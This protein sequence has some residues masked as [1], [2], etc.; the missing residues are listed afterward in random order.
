ILDNETYLKI[1]D[2]SGQRNKKITTR[3]D[4]IKKINIR[5]CDVA[6]VGLLRAFNEVKVEKAFTGFKLNHKLFI[7]NKWRG[8]N[9]VNP[10]GLRL[11]NAYN[12]LPINLNMAEKYYY[13]GEINKRLLKKLIRE[14]KNN[15][16][17]EI[18]SIR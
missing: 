2:W 8:V 18:D 17:E 16:K 4:K 11:K 13:L 15:K 5:V 10:D 1:E 7:D 12:L 14:Y 6:F 9:L 3:K